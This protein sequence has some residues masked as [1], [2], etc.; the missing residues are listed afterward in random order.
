MS[1]WKQEIADAVTPI[2]GVNAVK[3]VLSWNI[4]VID[5]PYSEFPITG[6]TVRISRSVQV[7]GLKEVDAR[8]VDGKNF[9]AEDFLTEI[10]FNNYLKAREPK[11]DDPII[12]NNG[13]AKNLE[14]MRPMT[15]NYGIFPVVDTL[16]IAG[17]EWRIA[18]IAAFGIMNDDS[19]GEPV[20]SKLR[21]TLRG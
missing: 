19:T 12:I 14:D 16:T 8:L 7:K 5:D 3:A 11:L 6:G 10:S 9:M 17:K 20:P 2:E 15:D 21:F 1:T 13:I 18:D 4:S